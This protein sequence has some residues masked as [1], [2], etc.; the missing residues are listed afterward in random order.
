MMKYLFR[1]C[2]L[3]ALFCWLIA[4]PAQ[5]SGPVIS[6]IEIKHI[7]PASVSDAMIR[8]NIRVKPGDQFLRI[9]VDD[10]VRSLYGTGLFYNIRVGEE[11]TPDG[12]VLT[13]VVQPKPR[14][15]AI[16]YT[17]NKKYA[18]KK[19]KKIVS[20]K[21]GDP[22]DEQKLFSDTQA[23]QK[24]YQGAGYPRTE[25][26]YV[27]NIDENSGRGTAT[28]E[29]QESPKV[30]IHDVVF[31]GAQAFDQKKLRGEI[32]TR[33]HW[34]WSWL[35]GSGVL[36]DD[37][38][39][40]DKEKLADFYRDHGYIDFEIKDVELLHPSP[41]WM[42][43]HFIIS[44]G[45]QYR[46]GS[47]KFTGNKIFTYVEITNGV[48]KVQSMRTGK[49][50]FGRNGLPMDVGDVFTP[51][52]LHKDTEMV[53]DFYGSR[54]YI[55]VQ[56]PRNLNVVKI[57]NTETG[58]M[59]L[60]FQIDEGQKS[61]IE[62]VEIRGNTKTKDKVIRREL[63]VSPGEVFD[64]VKM[65]LSKDRLEGLGYFSKVDARP[66][67]TDVPNRKNLV[68]GV[69]EGTTGHI[70]MG[71]GF[72]TVDSVVGYVEL[73]QGNFDLFHW[74]PPWFQGGGQK[75]RIRIQTGTVRQDYLIGF[76][77]PWF[78]GKKLKLDVEL[79]YHDL[80]YLSPNDLYT[81]ERGGG[82]VSLTRALGSDFIIGSVSYA[83]E[84]LGIQ[85]TSDAQP[86]GPRYGFQQG[87]VP[88]D[89]LKEKGY[90]VLNRIGS[91]LAIDTR[92][93]AKLPNHGQRSEI[94]SELVLG[95]RQYFKLESKTAWYFPGLAKGHVL[96]LGART[97]AAT[98]IGSDDVP[99]YD[100]YY[101]GGLDSLRGFKL[102]EVSPRQAGIEEPIG[103][104]TYWFGTAEYSIPIFE[105][106]HGVGVRVAL[107]Y[108]IGAVASQSYSY[109]TDYLDNW[110]IGLRLN[111][112]IGPL[113]LD[114]GIPITTDQY[115][116]SQGR[117]QFGVGYTH[118]F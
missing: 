83:I 86:H 110:G 28:F 114:Y 16:K 93:S 48:R 91:S 17:G 31:V 47:V 30:K 59:D 14:L 55:D 54:G 108:D 3:S 1:L 88:D 79:Y 60:D 25:V 26:K 13:Y 75:F 95:D 87:N 53:G 9:A 46:V 42:D 105:Q 36:K 51:K 103:G 23:I 96:E 50:Q 104:D 115:N 77:E 106:E 66:E 34:F 37:Q 82:K 5:P 94:S 18:E 112:P 107:F 109:S 97:G 39:E 76:T 65:K 67:S 43:I 33:R 89:M 45:T 111:L 62:K 85:L 4:A 57:P 69:D 32:K 102:R 44:E 80:A 6:K 7:G 84:N 20:S 64:L 70:T 38:F 71:A 117:F 98:G 8:A 72:S 21:V 49:T 27:L 52:G 113:R 81:E 100:R 24:L 35:T 29:I 101:L 15:T 11:M 41:K 56:P 63:A 99:F 40:E 2:G 10:D 22:L 58:T 73:N 19:F 61:Y 74:E 68:I 78:L 116:S 12:M 118:E 90:S 92:N